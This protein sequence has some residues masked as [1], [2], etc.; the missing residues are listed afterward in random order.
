M[1]GGLFVSVE[2]TARCQRLL[3]HEA[4]M[5]LA[6]LKTVFRV[7]NSSSIRRNAVRIALVVGSVLNLINQGP[8]LWNG[9]EVSLVNVAL[10]YFVPFCVS[11]YSAAKNQL[12]RADG[13]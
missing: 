3:S 2:T 12:A 13:R 11:S 4:V 10:N 1:A 9:S 7:A 6:G 5:S 8:A